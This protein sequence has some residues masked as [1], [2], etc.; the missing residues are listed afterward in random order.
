MMI[1][2]DKLPKFTGHYDN[3]RKC[4]ISKIL[5]IFGEEYFKDKTLLEVGCGYG[6]IGIFFRDLGAKV[7]LAE[8]RQEHIDEI[9][10]RYKDIE[11]IRLDQDRK[12]DLKRKF[13]IIIHMGVLYHLKHWRNDLACT[14]KHANLV[15]L[16]TEVANRSSPNFQFINPEGAGYDQSLNGYGTRAS[17]ANIEKMLTKLKTTFT[18]YDDKDL[19]SG[20]HI[21]DWQ[22]NNNGPKY[23]D[24]HRRFWIVKKS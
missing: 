12:W 15:I 24:S 22:V 4:R 20:Q 2:D 3:W 13:D 5:E 9:R 11:V 23:L 10:K 6:D 19:N 7:T 17:A 8:G 21:Y 18:R 1:D 16:E 14:F